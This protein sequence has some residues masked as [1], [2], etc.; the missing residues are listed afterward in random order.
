MFKIKVKRIR[1]GFYS[2]VCDGRKYE[3]IKTECG[4]SW[5]VHTD[6]TF[7]MQYLCHVD[8][9]KEGKLLIKNNEFNSY[10]S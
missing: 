6:L 3:I 5:T 7:D 4:T 8:T 9:L 2:I 1:S 10:F